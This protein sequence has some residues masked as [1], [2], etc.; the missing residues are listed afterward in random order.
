MET[1]NDPGPGELAGQTSTSEPPVRL[2]TAGALIAALPHLLGFSPRESMVLLGLR[3]PRDRVC[4]TVRLDL[5]DLGADVL[6]VREAWVD[7]VVGPLRRAG[8]EHV[9]VVTV[10]D[11]H[12]CSDSA[13]ALPFDHF[14]AALSAGLA[15]HGLGVRDRLL[16]RSGRWWSY[17]CADPACCGLPGSPIPDG[18]DDL[19]IRSVASGGVLRADRTELAALIQRPA[20]AVAAMERALDHVCRELSDQHAA[21]TAADYHLRVESDIRRRIDLQVRGSVRRLP[22]RAAARMALALADRGLRDRLCSICLTDQ[23]AAAESL[24][25]EL[26]RRC[27]APLDAAP[28]T[29]LALSAWARGDGALA[30]IALDRALDGDPRYQL[31]LLVRAGLDRGLPPE[32]VRHMLF[33]LAEAS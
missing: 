22:Q 28:A 4:L 10:T 21:G 17:D 15:A 3:P 1:S 11:L 32:S 23:A 2:G 30:N 19:A 20:T 26:L 9:V 12:E 24:W 18:S 29:L 5:P 16:S 8:A 31:A 27:P 7:A 25:I 13:A 6:E 33:G 14:S